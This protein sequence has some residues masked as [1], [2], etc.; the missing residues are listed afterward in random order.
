MYYEDLYV[1]DEDTYNWVTVGWIDGKDF[2]RKRMLAH[3]LRKPTLL[4][5]EGAENDCA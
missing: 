2:G 4:D 5:L 3:L 1:D